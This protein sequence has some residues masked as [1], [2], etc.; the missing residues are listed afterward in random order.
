MPQL[1]LRVLSEAV[2]LSDEDGYRLQVQWLIKENDGAVRAAGETDYRGLA[3]LVDPEVDW[4][5][6]PDQVVVYVPSRFVLMIGCEVP[7]RSTAQIKRAL[8]FAAEEYVAS[9]IETMHIA[10]GTIKPGAAVQCDI[11]AHEVLAAWRMCFASVGLNPGAFITDAHLLPREPGLVSLLFEADGA[12]V[13]NQDQVAMMDRDNLV[14]AINSLAPDRV[15]CINGSLTDIERGQ[16]DNNPEVEPIAVSK[17]GLLDYLADNY[18]P[19]AQ[20][21]LLQGPYNVERPRSA[22]NTRWRGVAALA[23]AWVLIAFV[24]MAVQG[25]WASAEAERLEGEGFAFY[26][27]VFPRESQP[28]S[29][30]QLRRRMAAKLGQKVGETEQSAFVGLLAQFSNVIDS[31]AKV[32]SLSFAGQ[33]QEVTIEVMVASYDALETVKDKLASSGVGLEV[34]S[35]EKEGNSV[36]SRLRVRYAP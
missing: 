11:V 22:Q 31:S 26:E 4:L 15:V 27:R 20:T 32:L 1:F 6:D 3:E 19:G 25:W 21:N 5:R 14:L 12:L 8:P 33:R 2:E 35:A 7:G 16:L 34:A 28:V 13:A 36:R 10:H 23:A 24:G 17:H 29:I 9:D 18:V 30:D